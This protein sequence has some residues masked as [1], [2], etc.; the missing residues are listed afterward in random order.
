[1]FGEVLTHE[2]V[3]RDGHAERGYKNVERVPLLVCP[4]FIFMAFLNGVGVGGWTGSLECPLTWQQSLSVRCQV[5]SSRPSVCSL[6]FYLDAPTAQMKSL[7]IEV[8]KRT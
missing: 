5:A 3:E 6:L 2:P 4:S 8:L 7:A 1:M